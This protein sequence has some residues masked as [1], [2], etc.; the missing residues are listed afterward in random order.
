MERTRRKPFFP[1]S[2]CKTAQLDDL[3]IV[4]R[5]AG[6]PQTP[7]MLLLHG[8]KRL[9]NTITTKVGTQIDGSTQFWKDLSLPF[10]GHTRAWW[11]GYLPPV[12]VSRRF[13]AEPL[14]VVS[15]AVKVAG[16]HMQLEFDM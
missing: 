1:S 15:H 13:S 6:D 5:E 11:P 8:L 4:D 10:Y 14:Q 3:K 2:S 7:A 12:F 9:M 16:G